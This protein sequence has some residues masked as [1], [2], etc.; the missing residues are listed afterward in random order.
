MKRLPVRAFAVAAVATLALAVAPPLTAGAA[1]PSVAT[2]TASPD[3][4]LIDHQAVTVTASGY[5]PHHSL[6]LVQC[7]QDRGCD[8]SNLQVHDSGDSGGYTATFFVRRQLN[9]DGLVVDCADAQ[10]CI[11][12]SVDITDESAG[13]QTSIAFDPNAPIPPPL[14][15]RFAV[16]P[17]G[18]VRVDKGVA[19]I[20]GTAHCNQDVEISAY[21]SLTQIWH[22]QIF[23]SFSYAD[24]LCTGESSFTAVF[25]P[26]NGLFGAGSATV[27]IDAYGSTST[28]YE[29][30][31]RATV[32]LVAK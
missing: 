8:F 13:A 17:T 14:H 32:T 9:L 29:I 23:Q 15:F 3:S 16:D 28:N 5:S 4:D 31:K 20:S 2:L 18:H 12:V 1:G 11:L 22:R 6:D 30:N 24:V 26:Q 19:R 7:V 27:H 21:L 25:R 10:D